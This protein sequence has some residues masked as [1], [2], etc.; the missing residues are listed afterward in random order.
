[1]SF[2][3]GYIEKN[4]SGLL[5]VGVTANECRS[6]IYKTGAT[7]EVFKKAFDSVVNEAIKKS[8]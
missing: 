2:S 4:N 3:D 6:I 1:M 7:I 8:I 5:F